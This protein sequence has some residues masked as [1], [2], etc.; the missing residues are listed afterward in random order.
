[1]ELVVS[2]DLVIA[3]CYNVL[4]I[5]YVLISSYHLLVSNVRQN[6]F[7]LSTFAVK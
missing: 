7:Y 5:V 6:V 1:M 3:T 2:C 4:Y